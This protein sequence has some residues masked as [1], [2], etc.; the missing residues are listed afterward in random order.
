[1]YRILSILL[2]FMITGFA[3][4]QDEVIIMPENLP[5]PILTGEEIA[6]LDNNN[7]VWLDNFRLVFEADNESY[8]YDILSDDVI[9]LEQSP[10]YVSMNANFLAWYQVLEDTVV[11]Q[12]PFEDEGWHHIL[13]LS[14]YSYVCGLNCSEYIS[15]AGWYLPGT[16]ENPD[17]L[18]TYA[19]FD[20]PYSRDNSLYWSADNSTL[21]VVLSNEFGMSPLILHH[22]FE[23]NET[24]NLPIS[25]G[26]IT[27]DRVLAISGDG[28]R[29]AI[30][31]HMLSNEDTDSTQFQKLYI[32]QAPYHDEL[33]ACT[34]DAQIHVIESALRQENIGSYFAGVGFVNE[35]TIL[36]I[37]ELGLMRHNLLTGIS[38]PI[39]RE[40]NV[41]WIRTAVFSPDFQHVAITT[42][43]GLFILPLSL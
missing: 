17:E 33:C 11:H 2:I 20:I 28:E 22:D 23:T 42:E 12:S 16:T 38:V 7:L 13:Y 29:V 36:Y 24:V 15:M 31:S 18:Y 30:R 19:P 34:Y 6:L 14:D 21:L 39:D 25:Y 43:Q 8:Q 5:N 10:F 26:D 3:L 1:M 27:R 41:G 40:L 37:G 4:A 32:W 9:Q 35:N